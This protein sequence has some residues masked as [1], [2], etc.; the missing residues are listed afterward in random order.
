M[1]SF[2]TLTEINFI[3]SGVIGTKEWF[4]GGITPA[5]GMYAYSDASNF[6]LIMVR[7]ELERQG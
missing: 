7:D 2:L 5:D 4:A 3:I 1:F 6:L